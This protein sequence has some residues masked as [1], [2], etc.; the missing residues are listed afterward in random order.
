MA[1]GVARWK[2]ARGS[3]RWTQSAEDCVRHIAGRGYDQDDNWAAPVVCSGL[4]EAEAEP[5]E[6][7]GAFVAVAVLATKDAQEGEEL[8]GRLVARV[9]AVDAAMHELVGLTP[10][11][12]AGER[13]ELVEGVVDAPTRAE[14]RE[15]R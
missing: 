11:L 12:F 15:V 13:E 7:V 6:L 10:H 1:Q 5:D 4:E 2:K 9:A 8:M 3:L 14:A